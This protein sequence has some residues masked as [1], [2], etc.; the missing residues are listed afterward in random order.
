MWV[1]LVS[2]YT[3]FAAVLLVLLPFTAT[4][5]VTAL[6]LAVVCGG[7]A[8]GLGVLVCYGYDVVLRTSRSR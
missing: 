5:V 1:A 7:V 2:G 8:A 3:V 4:P 6:L